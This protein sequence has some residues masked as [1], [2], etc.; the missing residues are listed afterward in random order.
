MAIQE[1]ISFGLPVLAIR[2]GNISSL[3]KH[4]ENGYLFDHVDQVITWLAQPLNAQLELLAQL[5]RPEHP[6]SNFPDWDQQA[7]LLRSAIWKLCC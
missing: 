7:T 4:G 2:G 5:N 1:A 3:V 6:E